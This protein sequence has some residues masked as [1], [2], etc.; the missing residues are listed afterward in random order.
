MRGAVTS[1]HADSPADGRGGG[2]DGG[3]GDG[4]V[5]LG[6]AG[7]FLRVGACPQFCPEW[8]I[9]GQVTGSAS[10]LSLDIGHGSSAGSPVRPGTGRSRP[11]TLKH[12]SVARKSSLVTAAG[13]LAFTA[14]WAAP[15]DSPRAAAQTRVGCI[16][17]PAEYLTA[18][19]T[20][21]RE[22]PVADDRL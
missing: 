10:L 11:M 16:S 18:W 2:A 19:N 13:M 5:L 14:A 12:P 4:G 17:T 1:R 7:A 3:H 6:I 9:N 15:S 8:A 21:R 22:G 20:A